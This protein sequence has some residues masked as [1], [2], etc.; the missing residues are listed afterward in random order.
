MLALTSTDDSTIALFLGASLLAPP[1]FRSPA[2]LSSSGMMIGT[3]APADAWS[4]GGA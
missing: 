4:T 1:I 2:A 3:P